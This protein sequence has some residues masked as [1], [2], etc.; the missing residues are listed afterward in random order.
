MIMMDMV[1]VGLVPVWDS[2]VTSALCAWTVV[3]LFV[4]IDC[5]CVDVFIISSVICMIRVIMMCGQAKFPTATKLAGI[6]FGNFPPKMGK[7]TRSGKCS[8]T[9]SDFDVIKCLQNEALL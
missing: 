6:F 5:V 1:C 9:S 2:G 7:D 8:M 4:V 3:G